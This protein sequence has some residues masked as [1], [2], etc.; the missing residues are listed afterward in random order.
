MKTNI[1]IYINLYLIILLSSNGFLDTE[2]GYYFLFW[3]CLTVVIYNITAATWQWAVLCSSLYVINCIANL[4]PSTYYWSICINCSII[5]DPVQ[6]FVVLET[7]ILSYFSWKCL[8]VIPPGWSYQCSRRHK[9]K[10][11]K[12]T[13]L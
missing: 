3:P 2:I 8:T 13:W 10:C 12:I 7:Y 5:A 4:L 1:D 6:N 11:F 9:H